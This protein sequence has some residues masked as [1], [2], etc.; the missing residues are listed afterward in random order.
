MDVGV[1]LIELLATQIQ[2]LYHFKNLYASNWS[3]I[4]SGHYYRNVAKFGFF[5]SVV[6]IHFRPDPQLVQMSI[7]LLTSGELHQ[8]EDL[9]GCIF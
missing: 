4:Q 1:Y 8:C 3:G 2:I 7:A 6:I 9:D 5:L